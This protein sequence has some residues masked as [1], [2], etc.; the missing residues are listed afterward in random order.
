MRPFKDAKIMLIE[1]TNECILS[2][3]YCSR[4]VR[5]V[6]K[7]FYLSTDKFIEALDSLQNWKKII[8]LIGGEATLHPQFEEF[9][10]I[11]AKKFP[12]RQRGLYTAGGK[13]FVQ[14]KD[15]IDETFGWLNFNNHRNDCNHQPNLIAPKDII[16]DPDLR[17][18]YIETC[19][20]QHKWSPSIGPN[21]LFFCEA[22]QSYDEIFKSNKGH[23]VTVDWWK[24]DLSEFKD[25]VD[26]FCNKCSICLPF[27][28]ESDQVVKEKISKSNLERLQ[29]ANSPYFTD[30]S[31]FEVIDKKMTE[32]DFDRLEPLSTKNVYVEPKANKNYYYRQYLYTDNRLTP[33]ENEEKRK[34]EKKQEMI[35]IAKGE[36]T[37]FEKYERK[38][39]KF[40]AD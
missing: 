28:G 30:E 1:L 15:L 7:P 20:L 2:C 21:G 38:V 18:K 39:K 27:A 22:A 26:H 32:Q 6:E 31:K 35:R 14:N 29:K 34:R 16:E 9:C 12:Y 10:H 36:L 37:E 4:N 33:E 24:K 25:Q 40:K 23:K 11:F 19:W 3:A 13:K 17:K 5:H 8:A